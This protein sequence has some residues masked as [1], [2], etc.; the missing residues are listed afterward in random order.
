MITTLFQCLITLN[1]NFVPNQ[2]ID[3]KQ[4][5][6]SLGECGCNFKYLML[7]HILVIDNLCI[8]CAA[9]SDESRGTSLMISH[10]WFS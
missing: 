6:L 3:H 10:L 1:T 2:H 5:E 7:K 9:V 4:T 8:P